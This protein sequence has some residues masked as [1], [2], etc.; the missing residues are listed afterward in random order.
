MTWRSKNESVIARSSAEAEFG[1]IAQGICEGLWI[2][3]MLVELQVI[4]SQ[5]VKLFCDNKAVIDILR[6]PVH[7]DKIKHTELD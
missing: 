4:M 5:P 7:H 2:K 1:A 6:N 3:K